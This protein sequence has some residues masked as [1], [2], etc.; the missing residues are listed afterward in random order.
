MNGSN[1]LQPKPSFNGLAGMEEPEIQRVCARLDA[2]IS[3]VNAAIESL[4]KN[5]NP[6]LAADPPRPTGANSGPVPA[7]ESPLGRTIDGYG[8]R[9][10]DIDAQLSALLRRLRI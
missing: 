3:A 6:V 7:A 4:E 10:L 8:D 2:R 5:L 1:S 9:I